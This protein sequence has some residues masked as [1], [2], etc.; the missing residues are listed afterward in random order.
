MMKSAFL[1]KVQYFQSINFKDY[2]DFGKHGE[3]NLDLKLPR[4]Y[5]NTYVGDSN[6]IAHILDSQ[7]AT[8]A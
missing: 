1:T 3:K 6:E 7:I 5:K 4:N 8:N 2:L